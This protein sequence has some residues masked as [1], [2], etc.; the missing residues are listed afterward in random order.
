MGAPATTTPFDPVDYT[1]TGTYLDLLRGMEETLRR[2]DEID[3]SIRPQLPTYLREGVYAKEQHDLPM[4]A[5][6]ARW[7]HEAEHRAAWEATIDILDRLEDDGYDDARSVL[8]QL[9]RE[10]RPSIDAAHCGAFSR[11]AH[12]EPRFDPRSSACDSLLQRS[13]FLG[14]VTG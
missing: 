6:S 12:R 8:E 3:P 7:T 1:R 9:Q 11:R 2:W 14:G 5:P 13:R 10:M 4:F